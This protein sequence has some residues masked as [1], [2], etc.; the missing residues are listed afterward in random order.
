MSALGQKQTFG[1]LLDMIDIVPGKML[2]LVDHDRGTSRRKFLNLAAS[3][4][5]TGGGNLRE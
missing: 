3:S 4:S 2:K 5:D 1:R